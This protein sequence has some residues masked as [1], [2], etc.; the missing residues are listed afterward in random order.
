MPNNMSKAPK[1]IKTYITTNLV[2]FTLEMKRLFVPIVA[3]QAIAITPRAKVRT[4]ARPTQAFKQPDGKH[5]RRLTVNYKK[6]LGINKII[7]SLED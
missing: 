6:L 4:V 3:E 1:T 2:S 7:R 5:M